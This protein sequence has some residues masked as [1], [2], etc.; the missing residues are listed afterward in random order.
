MSLW[1]AGAGGKTVSLDKRQKLPAGSPQPGKRKG[2]R[3]PYTRRTGV[4]MLEKWE[5]RREVC[6]HTG[7]NGCILYWLATTLLEEI[8]IGCGKTGHDKNHLVTVFILNE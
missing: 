1:D 6:E 7:G 5:G 3:G 8:T 2:S 4:T